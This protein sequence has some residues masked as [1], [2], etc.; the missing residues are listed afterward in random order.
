MK[1]HQLQRKLVLN[2][3]ILITTILQHSNCLYSYCIVII[4]VQSS[5][6]EYSTIVLP[7]VYV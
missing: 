7:T 2:L 5:I 6:I 4:I 3:S 1:D